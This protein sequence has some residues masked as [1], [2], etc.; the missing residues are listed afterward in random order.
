MKYSVKYQEE[1][2][3]YAQEYSLNVSYKSLTQVCKNI[4]GLPVAKAL[5]FLNKA[6][7]META[8]LFSTYNKKMGHRKEL[9]GKK[10]RY[11][12]KAVGMVKKV[13]L[14]AINNARV[15]QIDED[16]LVVAHIAANKQHVYSRLAPKGKRMKANYV[17]A[18][19]E[20]AL[21][22]EV[23]KIA[24]VSLPEKKKKKKV[25]METEVPKT[26]VEV[27]QE[28]S[29]EEVAEVEPEIKEEKQVKKKKTSKKKG[30]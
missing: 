20:I 15:L 25:E 23:K 27:E 14:N 19:L 30:E 8:V 11:P 9:G 21:K 1:G 3:S 29:V 4:K 6:E 2:Y 26:E 16:S 5:D 22:G 7:K 13:L 24:E 18:K 10:G 17:T 12:V 28:Q